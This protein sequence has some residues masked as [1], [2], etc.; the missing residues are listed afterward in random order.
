M[1]N[2]FERALEF[3]FPPTLCCLSSED[4]ET[5][6]SFMRYEVPVHHDTDPLRPMGYFDSYAG[7]VKPKAR[8]GVTPTP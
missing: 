7:R 3:F 8:F 2:L 1:R 5:L 4:S 6:E